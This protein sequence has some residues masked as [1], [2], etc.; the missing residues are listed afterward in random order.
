M[1]GNDDSRI[2]AETGLYNRDYLEQHLEREVEA[3]RKQRW[4]VS[5]VCIHVDA[6]NVQLLK[7]ASELLRTQTRESDVLA[8]IGAQEFAIVL[9]G[10]SHDVANTVSERLISAFRDAALNAGEG[11]VY[12]G[13]PIAVGVESL[14]EG[15]NLNSAENLLRG[16]TRA[17]YAANREGE[18]M[19]VSGFEAAESELVSPAAGSHN[20]GLLGRF[21]N[22]R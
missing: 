7:S 14:D 19:P 4:P 9:T 1:P 17:M 16:A 13:M 6:M 22:S 18:V 20:T 11:N 15:R 2:D 8:R 3:A 10:S 21:F 12:L 5:V